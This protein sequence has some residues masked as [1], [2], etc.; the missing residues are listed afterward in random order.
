MAKYLLKAS[1]TADGAKG[2]LK[3][4][5][6]G[7]RDVVRKMIEGLGGEMETF[8]FAFG[9]AD[10]YVIADLPDNVT[11][12]AI[13]VAVNAPGTVQ[14][15]TV[16]LLTAEEMDEAAKKAVDYRPPGG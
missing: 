1:Y 8:Y 7:R 3:D 12:A 13:S 2:V 15:G 9:E 4:G 16:T 14:L 11:A 6:T 10:V 5:G